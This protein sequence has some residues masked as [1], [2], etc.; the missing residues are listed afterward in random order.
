MAIMKNQMKIMWCELLHI[1]SY[2]SVYI[3]I[4]STVSHIKVSWVDMTI[5]HIN[6]VAVFC[7]WGFS[8]W[9]KYVNPFGIN[10]MYEMNKECPNVIWKD[11]G[12]YVHIKIRNDILQ[13]KS[14]AQ[15]MSFIF[16]ETIFEIICHH[17]FIWKFIYL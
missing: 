10:N 1:S 3:W 8:K 6:I 15:Y 16:K 14:Y 4:Y 13:F 5:Q 17:R 9:P 12:M 7:L 2:L 11:W